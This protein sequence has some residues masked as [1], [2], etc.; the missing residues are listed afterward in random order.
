MLRMWAVT[1]LFKIMFITNTSDRK[2]SWNN[3]YI[4]KDSDAEKEKLKIFQFFFLMLNYI[5]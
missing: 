1:Y 4:Y 2:D 5:V 3:I